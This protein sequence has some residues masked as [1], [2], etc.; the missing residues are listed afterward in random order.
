MLSWIVW[1]V[2]VTHVLTTLTFAQFVAWKAHI[3]AFTVFFLA[4]SL[5]AVAPF[6][7]STVDWI[8]VCLAKTMFGH[9]PSLFDL[10]SVVHMI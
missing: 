7:D 9:F 1:T 6:F 8:K 2:T 3:K 4:L 10:F 5:A